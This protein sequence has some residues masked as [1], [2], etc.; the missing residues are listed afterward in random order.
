LSKMVTLSI[1]DSIYKCFRL[2]AR[3]QV[4]DTLLISGIE[5]RASRI[6]LILLS[7]LLMIAGCSN[8]ENSEAP[9]EYTYEIVKTYPHDP[10]A[11]TQG[12]VFENGFLY[13]STGNYG[14]STLRMIDLETGKILRVYKLQ[15]KYFGEGMTI[16]KDRIYQL[17]YKSQMGFIY[18]KNSFKLLQNF[19]YPVLRPDSAQPG[20]SKPT[21]TEGWGLTNDGSRLIMS[22]GSSTLYFLDPKTLKQT[23]SIMVRDNDI[24]VSEL[25]ELEYVKGQIYANI[26]LTDRIAIIEL[27]TGQVTGWIYMNDLL[28]QQ[29]FIQPVDVLNGIAYDAVRDRLLVTGKF[30]PKLFEIKLVPLK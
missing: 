26:W 14:K 21:Q 8:K 30:W 29:D 9:T 23:G 19:K 28:N 4:P 27:Q 7:F 15:D 6:A 5:N 20:L 22:N 10:N 1:S 17:T 24:P 16:F 2:D 13:E 11:F 3:Y 25:N 18:D 12:L